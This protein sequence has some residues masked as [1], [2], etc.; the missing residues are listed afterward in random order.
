METI[1]YVD[2]DGEMI[3]AVKLLLQLLDY[4]TRS[5]SDARIAA[6]ALLAGEKPDLLMLD[7][8]MPGVT[9]IDLLEFV[10]YGPFHIA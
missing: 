2:D 1:W 9:G 3:R 6:K 10:I 7:I 4:E 8:N 5:L